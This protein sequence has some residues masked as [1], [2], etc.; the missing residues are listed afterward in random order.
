MTPP[1]LFVEK[2]IIAFIFLRRAPSQA[3]QSGANEEHSGG[4]GDWCG[5]KV[6]SGRTANAKN[7]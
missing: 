4:F 5:L 7:P 3:N 2:E 6:T 1:S